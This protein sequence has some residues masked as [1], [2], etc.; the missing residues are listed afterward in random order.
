M[1]VKGILTVFEHEDCINVAMVQVEIDP[2][3]IVKGITSGTLEGSIIDIL[4][5]YL[6]TI[7]TLF[8]VE[9][10]KTDLELEWYTSEIETVITYLLGEENE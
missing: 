3:K 10:I 1:K 5:T 4:L 2:K 8:A 9:L 6:P 7:K